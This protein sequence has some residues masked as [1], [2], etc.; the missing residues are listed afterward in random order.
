M[1]RTY[2]L[3]SIENVEAQLKKTQV[4]KNKRSPATK[5]SGCGKTPM[6]KVLPGNAQ[7]KTAGE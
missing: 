2:P 1:P 3:V 5:S 7:R 4:Q 6:Q